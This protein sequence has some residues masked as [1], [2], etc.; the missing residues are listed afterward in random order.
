M[1]VVLENLATEGQTFLDSDTPLSAVGL[2]A[3]G[4]RI[5]S[6]Y[7]ATEPDEGCLAVFARD[8]TDAVSGAP[9][10]R[11]DRTLAFERDQS[12]PVAAVGFSPDGSY[13]AAI[14]E[15]GASSLRGVCRGR[16]VA[17]FAPPC[18]GSTRL[19]LGP[20]CSLA[21]MCL[22]AHGPRAVVVAV[23]DLQSSAATPISSRSVVM[24]TAMVSQS[25]PVVQIAWTGHDRFVTVGAAGA[26]EFLLLSEASARNSFVPS[27]SLRYR[28]VVAPESVVTPEV[29]VFAWLCVCA[30]SRGSLVSFCSCA[31]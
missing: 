29:C 13:L 27:F 2:S 1:Q 3:D 7:A 17:P 4:S 23:W 24:A 15:P 6:G 26:V 10:W 18:T 21:L 12:M 16:P 28:V 22:S 5:A 20:F 31:G 11:L 25:K 30:R 8:G 14:G 19:W 9:A